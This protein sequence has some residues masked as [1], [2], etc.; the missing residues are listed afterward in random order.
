M[1]FTFKQAGTKYVRLTI[2]DA[3][4]KTASGEADVVVMPDLPPPPPPGVPTT[5]YLSSSGDD[6]AAG[7]SM[8]T[9]WKTIAKLQGMLANLKPGDSVLFKCGDVWNEQF[10]LNNIHG[11]A[12]NPR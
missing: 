1:S 9:P 4:G 10:N 8:L 3:R 2:T 7:T 5:F 12:G 11:A 6:S